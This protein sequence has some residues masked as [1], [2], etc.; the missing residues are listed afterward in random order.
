MLSLFG[1]VLLKKKRKR[2]KLSAARL[3]GYHF[4]VT[5]GWAGLS[6]MFQFL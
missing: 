3:Q 6:T 1:E 4:N 2:K 5:M